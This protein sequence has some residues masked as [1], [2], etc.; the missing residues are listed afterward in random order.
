MNSDCLEVDELVL[1]LA[2]YKNDYTDVA[3]EKLLRK[4]SRSWEAPVSEKSYARR[5]ASRHAGQQLR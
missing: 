1:Q 4:C 3:A 5:V 2:D